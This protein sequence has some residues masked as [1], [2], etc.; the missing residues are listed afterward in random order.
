M[1]GN[2]DPLEDGWRIH[3][4]IVAWTAN[5][6][7][8]ASFALAIESG[9]MAAIIGLAGEGRRLH[10]IRGS[11]EIAFLYGGVT[12]LG[13]ALLL[14]AWVVRPRLRTSAVDREWQ[15]NFV[16]FGHLRKWDPS[17][18]ERAIESRPLLPVLSRQIVAMSVVAWRKHKALQW[19][20]MLAVVGVTLV[21]IASIVAG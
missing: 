4:A 12:T 20:M 18:L 14:V 15:D 1:A 10:G 21:V 19:S 13:L 17:S 8:K 7:S 3:N 16:Y 2:P 9:I 5:V 6:D 11:W